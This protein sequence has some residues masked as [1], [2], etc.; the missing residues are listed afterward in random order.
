MVSVMTDLFVGLVTYPGTRFADSSGPEGVLTSLA[1]ACRTAGLSVVTEISGE[2][3]FD[4]DTFPVSAKD[5]R[6]SIRAELDIES[7]WRSYLS[8]RHQSVTASLI[9]QV[10][11][12][13][14]LLR[15][16]PPWRHRLQPNDAGPQMVR[17]LANIEMAHMA[18]F[19][20]A[21]A[22][23]A[24]WSLILEDDAGTNDTAAF[25]EQLLNFLE[26]MEGSKSP[27]MACLSESFSMES[28]GVAHLLRKVEAPQLPWTM[29]SSVRPVSNTVCATLYSSTFLKALNA[30]LSAIPMTPV[31][32]IDF[33][34]NE[35]LMRLAPSLAPGTVWLADPAPL[36]QRSGVP[37]VRR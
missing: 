14:R 5:I 27:G 29:F 19:H 32:P 18:L 10:R 17:R 7:R 21:Q 4:A 15:S 28:L 31:V 26:A 12:A 8:G 25:S 33:K 23:G 35:A 11:R 2:N 36:I 30:E 16:V 3:A 1:E 22:S 13:R 20:S 34:L 37:E 6:A 24:A 9:M